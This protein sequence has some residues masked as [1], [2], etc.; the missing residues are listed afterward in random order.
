MSE[1]DSI[2][3][4]TAARIFTDLA[5]PQSLTS[6]KDDTWQAPLWQALEDSGLTLAWV[7]DELGGAGAGIADG[8]EVI[9]VAGRFAAPVPIA[10]TLLAGWLLSQ[11]GITSPAGMMSVAPM[12]PG[13]RLT[14]NDDGTISGRA[15]GVAYAG[16]ADHLAVL[17]HGGKGL[18]VAL[19]P[20]KAARIA[21]RLGISGDKVYEVMFESARPLHLADAPAGLD[22]NALMLMGAA[23]RSLSTAGALAAILD[24]SVRYAG[25]R[26]AFERTISKFQAVQHNLARLAGESAAANAA[27]TSAADAI[28]TANGDAGAITSPGLFLEVAA[29]RIRSAEAATEGAAIAHQVHG[30][31]GY[32]REHIL[33]RFT[34]ALLTWRDDFGNESQWAVDLGNR[35]AAAG[36]EALWPLVASR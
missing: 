2:V 3:A 7:P 15:R 29:A 12:R 32:T 31:I 5:D 14:L 34:R 20:A 30:A 13:D 25:E 10:E 23:T 18:V 33:H 11:A 4:E 9:S 17:A 21:E 27:A 16:L 28:S 8:F 1:N 26:V 24:I 36:S 6:A 35:V 19:M 22:Q